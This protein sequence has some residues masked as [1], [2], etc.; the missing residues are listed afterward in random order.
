MPTSRSDPLVKD[1]M[2]G[3]LGIDATTKAGDRADWRPAEPPAA[4]ME[5][6]RRQFT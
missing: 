1:G 6:I 5:R 3:K 2:V 4:V